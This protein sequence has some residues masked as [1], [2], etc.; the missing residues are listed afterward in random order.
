MITLLN[1]GNATTGTWSCTQNNSCIWLNN[2]IIG[3]RQLH[4]ADKSSEITDTKYA[5]NFT[6]TTTATNPHYGIEITLASSDCDVNGFTFAGLTNVHP[7]SGLCNFSASYNWKLRNIGSALSPLNLGSANASGVI[8]N[9]AGNNDIGL[10]QRCYVQN[11]RVGAWTTLNNDNNITIESL[12][13]DYADTSAVSALNT[14]V[15]NAKLLSST[16]GQ[17]A[18]Y[19]SH[20]ADYFTSS[21]VGKITV[22]CNEP[23]TSSSA[24]CSIT[25]GSPK[26]NSTGSLVLANLN[27]QVTWEMPY[28]AKG[29]LT[30]ANL[31]PTLTGTNI[32]NM[33]FEFQYD[34]GTGY[35]G[36]WLTA[37]ASNFTSAGSITNTAGVRLKIRVT[38]TVANAGNLLTNISIPTTTTSTDQNQTYPLDIVTLSLTNLIPGSD[39]VILQAGTSNILE[40]ADSISGSIYNYIYETLQSVDIG[41][42]KPGYKPKYQRNYSLSSLNSSIPMTQELD[43]V[44][45]A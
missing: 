14:T 29:H 45:S 11:T 28:F 12:A 3:G 1:R 33:L 34:K 5:D 18:V 24:Q 17:T 30:L 2:L 41:V 15:K 9:T 35:N 20:F 19:G 26:F 39:V 32:G 42:I 40:S 44:Y 8:F 43:R 25:S 31:A 7:Y 13:A 21:T 4:V 38:T 37:N 23:T 10:I 22:L 36:T 27:D 16:T 6:G